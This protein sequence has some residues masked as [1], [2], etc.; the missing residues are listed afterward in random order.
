[1]K[2]ISLFVSLM[3]VASVLFAQSIDEGKK[4]LNY[5][6][7]TGA[8][9]VFS[10]LLT[11][12]PNNVE[13]AYWLGQTYL[14]NQDTPDSLAAKE[15]YQKTLQANPNSTLMLVGMGEIDLMEGRKDEA[16]NKFEAAI[17]STKKRDLPDILLPI[18]R[19]NID[20]RNGDTQYA[21]QKLN[22][23]AERDKK[24]PA[25]Q[26]ALG[27]AYRKLIDGANA[28][29]AYQNAIVMDPSNAK[30]S[31][32]I[33]RIYETQGYGQENIY[34]KYYNDAI[35]A[36]SNYAPVYY[37]LYDYYYRRD[38]NKAREY[39]SKY[40]AH[41]DADSKN[42]YAEASL[43]YVSQLYQQAIDKADQCISSP[44][45]KIF[46]NLYGL[47]AYSYD[48]L[49]DSVNAKK[50]FEEFFEKVNPDKIGP[51]DYATYGRILLSFPDTDSL[52]AIYV[53]KAIDLDTIPANKLDYVK[54]TAASLVKNKEYVKAGNWYEKI[55]T[56]KPDYGKVDLYY[57]GYNNY[58]GGDYVK[59]DSIFGLYMEKYP[60]DAFGAYMRARAAE[61]IDTAGVDQLAKP[62]Y[63]KVIAIY[64]TA[65]DKST[66]KDYIIPAYRYMVANSYNINKNV[67]SALF[68]NEHI[69]LIDPTDPTAIKTKEALMGVTVKEKT[70]T[71]GDEVKEKTKSEG[72]KV[73]T[74][75]GQV[76]VK[77]K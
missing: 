27:D 63:Q 15:L 54:S 59:A 25:I 39:L 4:Y 70:K 18:A 8:Q 2:K 44:G 47:K 68:Y 29:I 67:D 42:C 7:Y 14:Q 23:A 13:A 69:L 36:D 48:K 33:G 32:M 71:D 16:R 55:L 66:V 52:A 58:R 65:N 34:M 51:N 75:N 77:S 24:N 5:E 43:F 76:K 53:Q 22:E 21:I 62:Y 73:K 35:A 10:K 64:D 20:T 57:A 60:E 61:G 26:I 9:D 30:P 46:P 72:M 37:W 12:D 41:S 28:T 1:M 17:S 38:V 31:F 40:I 19:A 45:Q 50:Y 3:L 11:A 56:L 74:K 6:R 49:G